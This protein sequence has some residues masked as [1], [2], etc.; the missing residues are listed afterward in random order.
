M[1]QNRPYL[2]T[3]KLNRVSFLETWCPGNLW[4]LLHFC[5]LFA[6]G[7]HGLVLNVKCYSIC[8]LIVCGLCPGT[9]CSGTFWPD[10]LYATKWCYEKSLS[11]VIK[12]VFAKIHLIENKR[13]LLEQYGSM[14]RSF[15]HE[16]VTDLII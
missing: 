7:I 6:R 1:F 13:N 14:W 5:G 8:G 10:S 11:I 12:L 16:L 2:S 3:N 15:V 4:P 9:F